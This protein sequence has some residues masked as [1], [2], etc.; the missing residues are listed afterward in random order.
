M[1]NSALLTKELVQ[2][3]YKLVENAI[4]D[5]LKGPHS[6]KEWLHVVVLDPRAKFGQ[7][8]YED[9]V[10]FE[11]S[12]NADKWDSDLKDR[13][14]KKAM[15]TWEHGMNTHDVQQKRPYLFKKGDNK[16]A[17]A[18]V[19]EGIIVS[20]VAIQWYFDELIAEWIAASCR[21]LALE[22]MEEIINEKGRHFV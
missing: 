20:V 9:A 19:H 16:Y 2:E 6:K 3:A 17:G 5:L 10:I 8:K 11:H 18:V 4:H 13:A 12:I 22:K 1:Q 14:H 7:T 15:V 21:A